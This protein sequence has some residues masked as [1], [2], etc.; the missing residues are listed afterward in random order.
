[1]PQIKSEWKNT[2][3]SSEPEYLPSE[4]DPRND[5]SYDKARALAGVRVYSLA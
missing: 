5:E 3:G 2:F 1:L 4:Y